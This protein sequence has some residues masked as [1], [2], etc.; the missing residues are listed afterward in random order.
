MVATSSADLLPEPGALEALLAPFADPEIG[1][2]GCRVIP[3]DDRSTFMGFA[4]HLL[5]DLHHQ[6]NLES[7]KG[8]EMIAF[9]KVFGRLPPDTAVDEASIEPVI[10]GQGYQVCYAPDAIVLN[11]GPDT[12]DDFLLQRRRIYAGHLTERDRLGYEVS[13]MNGRR[14]LRLLLR[15]LDWRPKQFVWTWRVVALEIL[16]RYLGWRDFRAHRDHHIWEVAETT[17]NL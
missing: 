8:G 6:V 2:T 17:K 4:T 16:G 12:V 13:T 9:R 10:I 3:V 7:F 15:S 14:I 1:M 5:W 11:K